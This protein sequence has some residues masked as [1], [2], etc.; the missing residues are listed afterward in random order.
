MTRVSGRV[1]SA[2]LLSI[3]IVRFWLMPLP[4]GFW[5]DE[6]V[7]AFVL[8]FPGHPSLATAPQVTESIYYW[9]PRFS[10]A[11]FGFSEISLRIP[12]L[13]AMGVTLYLVARLAAR[14]IHPDATW[15]AVFACLSLHGID[16]FAVDARPY[17]LGIA[18]ATAS[19]WF[20]VRWLDRASWLDECAFLICAALLWRV[21]LVYWPFYSVYLIYAATRL[22]AVPFRQMAVAA[23]ALPVSL[24]PVALRAAA[25]ARE[26]S[27]HAFNPPPGWRTFEHLLHWNLIL[28]CGASAWVLAFIFRWGRPTRTPA[29]P[30]TFLVL[31]WW[32]CVPVSLFL[33]SWITGNGVYIAR[34]L[35]L[36]LPGVALTATALAAMR[37]PDR[38]WMPAAWA[39]ALVALIWMG[40]WNIL[41]PPHENSGWRA[42]AAA[43]RR[44]SANGTLVI[45]PSP[46]VEAR[47]PVWNPGYA[48]PGFLYANLPFYPLKG[49]FRLFPFDKSPEAQPY[50]ASLLNS[51]LIP[52][53]RFLIY[54]PAGGVR[55]WV[56]WY[57]ARP[58]L[59]GWRHRIAEFGDVY[60]AMFL[61]K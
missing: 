51:E 3:C 44:I 32:L 19:L 8:R 11:L 9:L 25:I 31:A 40:Q 60:L 37:L 23:I 43:E 56:N 55:Y 7:T 28:I 22:T 39:V 45:L 1:L 41:W 17:S 14:L 16:Y 57:A 5:I 12:S 59:A 21:H 10:T 47:P 20:L 36:M 27:S 4:S 38:C 35:S 15:F 13:L 18:L 26:A 33:Y 53:D 49:K 34:Y 48:L 2:V 29:R 50:A 52:S 46:F 30:E 42:A 61:K 58:E 24:I 54:G 6:L